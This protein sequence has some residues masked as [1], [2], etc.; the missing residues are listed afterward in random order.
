MRPQKPHFQRWKQSKGQSP[1]CG[2][3]HKPQE[4]G[5]MI[6]ISGT[7]S[8]W[9]AFT[10]WQVAPK[11]ISCERWFRQHEGEINGGRHV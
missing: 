4:W 6:D 10:F 5:E 3:E 1:S 9:K 2:K 11:T 8:F 7:I